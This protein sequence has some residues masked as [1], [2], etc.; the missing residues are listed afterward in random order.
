MADVSILIC[1]FIAILVMLRAIA[2]GNNFFNMWT[3]F[4]S[5]TNYLA[6]TAKYNFSRNINV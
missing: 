4:I 3:H 1:D 2:Y 6:R 5:E